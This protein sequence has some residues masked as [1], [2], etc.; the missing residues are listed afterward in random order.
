MATKAR[1]VGTDEEYADFYRDN[2]AAPYKSLA[3]L[4]KT[5]CGPMKK[6]AHILDIGCGGA[7][8]IDLL[9]DEF[10]EISLIEPNKYF[11]AKWFNRSWIND[12][13]HIL[14]LYPLGI[15]QAINNGDIMKPNIYDAIIM[16][17][18]IYHFEIESLQNTLNTITNSL[19]PNGV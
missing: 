1:M 16:Y 17:H 3:E 6:G 12:N 8:T 2:N 5:E 19:K 4:I 15:E 13:K 18:P 14:H 9:Q 10:N 7:F 11:R